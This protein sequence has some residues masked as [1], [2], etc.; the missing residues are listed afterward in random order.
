MH[1]TSIARKSTSLVSAFITHSPSFVAPILKYKLI[2][3]VSVFLLM[4]TV[5][6]AAFVVHVALVMTV[7]VV[8]V[9]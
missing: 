2:K 7:V 5:L 3:L 6:M 8:V 1:A 9:A 4:K